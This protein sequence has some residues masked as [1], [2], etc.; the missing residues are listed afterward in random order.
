M[1]ISQNQNWVPYE[2]L[3]S[4]PGFKVAKNYIH[5]EHFTLA[6]AQW[7]SVQGLG[8]MGRVW[9]EKNVSNPFITY[10]AQPHQFLSP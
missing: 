9:N 5:S 3:I 6:Q 10:T 2:S 7:K 4:K 8:L 1:G